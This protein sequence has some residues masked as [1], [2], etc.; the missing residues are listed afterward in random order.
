MMFH[1]FL[2]NKHIKYSVQH[3]NKISHCYAL[4][5]IINQL[6]NIYGGGRFLTETENCFHAKHKSDYFWT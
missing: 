6:I 4:Q 2:S 5:T 1:L 3:S